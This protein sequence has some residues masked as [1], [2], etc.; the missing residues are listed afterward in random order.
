MLKISSTF[1]GLIA[2]AAIASSSL[3]M[4]AEPGMTGDNG[5]LT[6][7]SG[8]TLYTFDKDS[9]GKSAC[10]DTCAINWPPLTAKANTKATGKWTQVKRSDGTLQWAYDG[11]PLY[12]Y[13]DD[14]KAG[15]VTGDGKGGAWHIVKP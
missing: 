9:V 4:A 5:Y 10:N 6:D 7:H 14:K 8:K 11:K 3:V 12:L 2:A 1:M 15:D 13:K